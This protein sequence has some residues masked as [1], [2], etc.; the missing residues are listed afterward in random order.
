MKVCLIRHGATAGNMEHRYV[1]STDE[2]LTEEAARE[3]H[4]M[5]G[6]YPVPDFVFTS[7]LKRCTQTAEILFP[8]K[9]PEQ[10]FG[11]REC[12]FGDFEYKNYQELQ[13]DDRYQAWIDS[14]GAI[15]FP[16]GESRE[17]FVDRCCAAFEVCCRRMLSCGADVVAFVVH[18]G[19]IMAILDRYSRPHR[20]YFD[21]QVP[22]AHGFLCELTQ[23]DG[24]DAST[25]GKVLCAGATGTAGEVAGN[26]TKRLVIKVISDLPGTASRDGDEDNV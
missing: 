7:P 15:A 16:G 9:R 11:L 22:N 12:A 18:G 10:C 23:E 13:G 19:T 3:L 25:L 5:R 6:Q 1:G 8:E 17:A 26:I 21:W 24:S 14:G 4:R 2:V 20:D